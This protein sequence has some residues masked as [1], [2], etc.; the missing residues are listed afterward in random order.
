MC[1]RLGRTRMGRLVN[2][3]KSPRPDNRVTMLLP[4]CH[5]HHHGR[6]DSWLPPPIVFDTAPLPT[7]GVGVAID[8]ISDRDKGIHNKWNRLW[9]LADLGQRGLDQQF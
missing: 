8:Y 7:A 4:V 2:A 3:T 5:A 6:K 9:W 1:R